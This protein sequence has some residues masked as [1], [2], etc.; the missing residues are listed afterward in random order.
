MEPGLLLTYFEIALFGLHLL[1]FLSMYGSE[2]S[3][4]ARLG[5]EL[6]SSKAG[7][8][9]SQ[10][11]GMLSYIQVVFVVVSLFIT[12][13]LDYEFQKHACAH[14]VEGLRISDL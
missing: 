13:Y 2:L 5:P 12:N 10:W 9:W 8:T 11:G 7:A 4:S 1:S 14:S 6:W 3:V